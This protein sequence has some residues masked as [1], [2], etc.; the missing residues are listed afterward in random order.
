MPTISIVM[1]DPAGAG[2]GAEG[3]VGDALLDDPPLH[4]AATS[5]SIAP[6]PTIPVSP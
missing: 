1:A 4:P 6:A 2:L 5:R 3:D